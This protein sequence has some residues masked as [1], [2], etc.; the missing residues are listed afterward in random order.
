M[1][2]KLSE[3]NKRIIIFDDCDKD[4]SGFI[5]KNKNIICKAWSKIVNVSG[6]EITKAG[7]D[8]SKKLTRFIVR[9]RKDKE[10]DTSMKIL[11]KDISYNIKYINNYNES[12]EF[13]ELIGEAII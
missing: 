1:K 11:Y 2:I 12:D 4:D 8:F 9:Y 7:G 6:T 3:L 10:I 5:I 13:L